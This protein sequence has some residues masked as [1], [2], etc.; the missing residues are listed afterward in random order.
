MKRDKK[1]TDRNIF[2]LGEFYIFF[3]MKIKLKKVA[4]KFDTPTLIPFAP[5]SLFFC[6]K[7][8]IGSCL[9]DPFRVNSQ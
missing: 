4:L 1:V 7:Y 2:D 5:N 8:N 6:T 3:A 9:F